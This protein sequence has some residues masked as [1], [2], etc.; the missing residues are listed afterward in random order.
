MIIYYPTAE[1]DPA[2]PVFLFR[3]RARAR[4]RARVSRMSECQA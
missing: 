4:T 1:G 3:A 2:Y